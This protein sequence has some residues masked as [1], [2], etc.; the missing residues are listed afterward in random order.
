[1]NYVCVYICVCVNQIKMEKKKNVCNNQSAGVLR[2]IPTP[3]KKKNNI[4]I[5][6]FP[7][8]ETQGKL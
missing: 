2:K 8:T 6:S 3:P 7:I 5:Y 4:Q 1:M